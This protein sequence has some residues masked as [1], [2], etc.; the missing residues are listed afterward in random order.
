MPSRWANQPISLFGNLVFLNGDDS[1]GACAVGRPIGR[2]KVDSHQ[3]HC[4]DLVKNPILHS[5]SCRNSA[6]ASASALDLADRQLPKKRPAAVIASAQRMQIG[7]PLPSLLQLRYPG[8]GFTH[9]CLSLIA[10]TGAPLLRRLCHGP[11]TFAP[12]A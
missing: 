7:G 11:L 9:T 12:C 10:A 3:F 1:Y 8:I 2:F 6:A 4:N 5:A